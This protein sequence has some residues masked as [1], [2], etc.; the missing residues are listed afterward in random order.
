ME[1]SP[2]KTT[3]S[4]YIEC[5]GR[6]KRA[7]ARVRLAQKGSGKFVINEKEINIADPVWLEPLKLVGLEGKF[8]FSIHVNG[9]G[10]NSQ[11]DAIKLGISRALIEV[12]PELRPALRKSDYLK[13]DPREKERKKPGLRRARRAPQWAKR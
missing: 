4:K 1:N 10:F 3:K 5:I 12:D 7:I 9:G 8:D 13:R 11:K 2:A 6:R